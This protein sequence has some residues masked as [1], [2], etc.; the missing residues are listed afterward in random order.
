MYDLETK[1]LLQH[2]LEQGV[3]K[4]KL[5]RRFQLSRRTSHYCIESG[6]LERELGAGTAGYAGGYSRVRDFV[7]HAR[8]VVVA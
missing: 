4:A 2:Y 6:Q 5:A 3:S 8:L 1:M 7:R